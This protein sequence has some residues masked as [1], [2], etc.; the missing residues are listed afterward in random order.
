MTVTAERTAKSALLV[1]FLTPPSHEGFGGVTISHYI[2]KT[3]IKFLTLQ[4]CT[5][6]DFDERPLSKVTAAMLK[7]FRT[8]AFAGS[9]T[10]SE[11]DDKYL[12][13]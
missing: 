2:P 5:L 9:F 7:A 12:R 13:F 3:A 10:A 6:R 8:Y 11:R 1:T 4:H